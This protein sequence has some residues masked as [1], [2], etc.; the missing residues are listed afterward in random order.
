M[1]P[2]KGGEA[3]LLRQYKSL[4]GVIS[5]RLPTGIEMRQLKTGR[6]W[7]RVFMEAGMRL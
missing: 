1:R 3:T 7:K 6:N 2:A 5:E 4:E